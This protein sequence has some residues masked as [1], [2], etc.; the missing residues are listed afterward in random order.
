MDRD[1]WRTSRRN[2]FLVRIGAAN[3]IEVPY[4]VSVNVQNGVQG[5]LGGSRIWGDPAVPVRGQH[6][7][8]AVRTYQNAGGSS[9]LS[10][11]DC[12]SRG[13]RSAKK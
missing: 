3:A 4:M 11:P 1:P 7:R 5:K 9:S 13:H 12:I 8:V 10:P 6:G 2:S